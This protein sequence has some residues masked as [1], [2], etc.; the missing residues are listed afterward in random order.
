MVSFA[1]WLDTRTKST[2]DNFEAK[3]PEATREQVRVSKL[4]VNLIFQALIVQKLDSNINASVLSSELQMAKL[5]ISARKIS[6]V[7]GLSAQNVKI[8][9]ASCQYSSL[10]YNFP[11]KEKIFEISVD[12]RVER[13]SSCMHDN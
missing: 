1:V 4:H 5:I 8:H 3:V 9:V 7:V 13:Y 12:G 6:E 10:R 2:V 11:G